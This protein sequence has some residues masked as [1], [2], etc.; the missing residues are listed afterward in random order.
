MARASF[1]DPNQLRTVRKMSTFVG[2]V[3]EK[4]LNPHSK[5][6]NKDPKLY[7][8]GGNKNKDEDEDE[9]SKEEDEIDFG[10]DEKEDEKDFVLK[11]KK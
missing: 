4:W 1:L 7:E 10:M 8:K 3:M 11:N 2:D 5:K 9:Y 6:K